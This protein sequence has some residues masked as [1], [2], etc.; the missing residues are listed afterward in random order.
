MNGVS[1]AARPAEWTGVSGAIALLIVRFA[2]V[3]DPDVLVALGTIFA[4]LPA[5]V[6]W[7]VHTFRPTPPPPPP[8][9][10]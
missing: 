2:D 10:L 6:T 7:I 4:A 1:P 9:A 8:P 5:L 3:T